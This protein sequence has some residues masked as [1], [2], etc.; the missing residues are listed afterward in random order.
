MRRKLSRDTWGKKR[1][2]KSLKLELYPPRMQLLSQASAGGGTE[3]GGGKHPRHKL[4][5]PAFVEKV[6]QAVVFND[7]IRYELKD[8][9]VK[10]WQREYLRFPPR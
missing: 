4:T 1:N 5:E 2:Q 7:G 9:M 10:T 8:G 6:R 3:E